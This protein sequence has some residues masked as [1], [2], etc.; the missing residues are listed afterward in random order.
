MWTARLFPGCTGSH[1]VRKPL[2][3]PWMCSVNLP[4]PTTLGM[5]VLHQIKIGW[6][7]F[8]AAGHGPCLPSMLCQGDGFPSRTRLQTPAESEHMGGQR[9]SE[10]EGRD[11]NPVDG[12]F[13]ELPENSLPG[14]LWCCRCKSEFSIIRAAKCGTGCMSSLGLSHRL[15][16]VFPSLE[17]PNGTSV[18]RGL[19]KGAGRSQFPQEC[20]E[21]QGKG[22]AWQMEQA[23]NGGEG[24]QNVG[25]LEPGC[26][27]EV[28][29]Q[30]QCVAQRTD[31]KRSRKHHGGH[32]LVALPWGQWLQATWKFPEGSALSEPLGSPARQHCGCPGKTGRGGQGGAVSQHKANP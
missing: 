13:S 2:F 28:R 17:S 19:G 8:T 20:S 27:D 12:P 10:G 9:S 16:E 30:W 5:A 21:T 31:E 4:S 22:A 7:L 6:A 14:E 11:Q 15:S 32:A 29:F 25:T 23:R 24:Q 1:K 26:R 3:I 18:D